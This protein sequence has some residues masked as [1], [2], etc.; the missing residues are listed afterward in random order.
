MINAQEARNLAK[1][2]RKAPA[3]RIF[4]SIKKAADKG[5]LS[6]Y[7]YENLQSEAVEAIKT[8]GFKV[9]RLPDDPRDQVTTYKISWE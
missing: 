5:E 1:Q 4:E 9:V 8:Q 3:E 2:K 6:I 7:V